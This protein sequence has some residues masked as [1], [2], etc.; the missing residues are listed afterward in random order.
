MNSTSKCPHCQKSD[1]EVAE[2][3]LKDY[4]YKLMFVRCKSCKTVVGV[5]DCF[6]IGALI[7]KLA[8][9]LKVDLND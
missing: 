9:K 8:D 6:N 1:F 4:I 7:Y 5:M 3:E 2:E